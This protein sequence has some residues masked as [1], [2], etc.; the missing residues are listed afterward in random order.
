MMRFEPM[1]S[2][3]HRGYL[4]AFRR[5]SFVENG[6]DEEFVD[7]GIERIWKKI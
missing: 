4:I 5:D 7:K 1:D 6:I 3:K 2:Y